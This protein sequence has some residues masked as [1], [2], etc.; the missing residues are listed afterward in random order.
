MLCGSTLRRVALHSRRGLSS[1]APKPLVSYNA[2]LATVLAIFTGGVYYS[3][4]RKAARCVSLLLLLRVS[5]QGPNFD[6]PRDS[7][8]S[9]FLQQCP[10]AELVKNCA[11]ATA[12]VSSE[13]SRDAPVQQTDSDA[14]FFH[15]PFHPRRGCAQLQG[16]DEIEELEEGTHSRVCLSV[17]LFSSPNHTHTNA[18]T[19]F[20]HRGSD[21]R[22]RTCRRAVGK[23]NLHS[24]G[25][26]VTKPRSVHS[27]LQPGLHQRPTT[28]SIWNSV[29]F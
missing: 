3:A 13:G 5:F 18:R 17:C 19:T 14:A 27:A 25:L 16:V 15:V 12:S 28:V 10:N 8:D 24:S 2:A 6:A 21:A 7:N 20:A 29:E 26:K 9:F 4:I 23:V 1:R 22:S 11:L